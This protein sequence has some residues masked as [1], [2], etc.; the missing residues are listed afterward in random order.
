M[1]HA[2]SAEEV[3]RELRSA[4]SGLNE[5]EA[6]LR[7]GAYGP[8]EFGKGKPRTLL[9]LLANQFRN[10]LLV[11]LIIASL[12][13]YSIGHY[14]DAAAIGVVV[15]LNVI[16]G[17]ALEYKADRSMEELKKL[18]ETK[19]VVKRNGERKYV[20]SR[21]IVPGDITY[22]E[23]GAKV[24]ADARLLE[25]H[26]LEMNE[27]S[28]T[29]ES[30]PVGKNVGKV[31][32]ETPLAERSCMLFAGTFVARGS[33]K[34]VVVATGT[35]TEFGQIE[36]T[37]GKVKEEATT[38]EKTL[39][40]LGKTITLASFI[41]VGVLFAAGIAFGKWNVEDLF[42]YS[43]SVIVAAVPE[44]MLTILTLVLA[45]GVK[46]MA[47]EKALVRRLQSVETLGNIT[48]IATD[49]T[50]TITEG[51][52]AL[53]KIYDAAR[54]ELADFSELN[55]TE[56]LL[57]YSYLCNNAHL[58]DEGVVGD[59]TDRAFLIAGIVKGINVRHFKQISPAL[60]F[61]PFDSVKK[62]MSGVY[63]VGGKKIAIVKGAPESVLGMCS[64]VE[65]KGKANRLD[66]RKKKE[67][68]RNMEVL[69]NEGM[70][71]IAIAYRKPNRNKVPE[72]GFTFLGLLALHDPVRAEVK[73][74]VRVCRKAGIRV[75]MMTGDNLSTAEKIAV[76]AGLKNGEGIMNWSELERMNDAELDGAL[77]HISVIARATP[78]SKLRIVE[79]LVKQGEIVAVSGDGV[80]D[81]LA[82][83]KA[84][85]AVVMGKTGTDVSKEVA[86]LVLMDDNF[87]TLE[88]AV[89]YG[90]GI[91][92]N[93]TNFLRFQI[94]TNLALV[95]LSIPYVLGIKLLEPAHILWINLIID[96]PPAL[97]LGL[98]KPGAE[99]M[100][101]KPKRKAVMIDREFAFGVL[102]MALY[103]TAV[104]ILIYFY[105]LK[106]QPEKA[107]TMVFSTF[108]FMQAFNALNS[109]S[110][111][112][113][114]YSSLF[115]NKW[116]LL[117][118]FAVALA[119][120]TMIFFAPLGELFGTVRLSVSDILVMF[121]ASASV[122][123]VG[124]VRKMLA[125]N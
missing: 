95:L 67:I 113:H 100:E 72:E 63:E 93:I 45:I 35:N 118:V 88:K 107:I 54:K 48:F 64:A 66:E 77:K 81:A 40:E 2:K 110:V 4:E 108:A 32:G 119:Q 43:V 115:S 61:S 112:E 19:A 13:A 102:N 49:K 111:K 42:V 99:I 9:D 15:V 82:L 124:E 16:F 85:V 86:D 125:K 31:A 39:A 34:A 30:M 12:V 23:E 71:V 14:H 37:L 57:S 11:L 117:A 24:P 60:A 33:A 53:V 8:N 44:G 121:V 36:K 69:A 106:A 91:A 29:G 20:D 96:G 21:L 46:N 5:R 7:L 18:A 22:L 120:L 123:V 83:K 56:R 27:A 59:E 78:A 73:E 80:N 10:Y 28:L 89:E 55:G 98:E 62:T 92:N 17:M 94:T 87:A 79:R 51:R 116:L 58:T 25:A 122:L 103:M 114:F 50:G 52:M 84:H 26:D 74:T 70:R 41:I 109:R 76:Q 65:R 1:F 105:Y 97:T 38:L 101:Q 75:L 68:L 90:R 47:N 104:S 6:E 3:L